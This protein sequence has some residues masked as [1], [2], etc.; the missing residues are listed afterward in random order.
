MKIAEKI[1]VSILA[2]HY[3]TISEM[4]RTGVIINLNMQNDIIYI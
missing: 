3:L 1:L 2:T 4:R